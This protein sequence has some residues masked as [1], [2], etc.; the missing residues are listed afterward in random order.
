M[1]LK[2]WMKRPKTDEFAGN[3]DQLREQL[4]Q[5]GEQSAEIG[6]Q[7]NKL[8][9]I[10]Y[11]T[12]QEILAKIDRITAGMDAVQ[13]WQTDQEVNVARLNEMERQID[14]LTGIL[15]RWL[16]DIDY[17][18]AGLQGEDQGRWRQ[19]L[20]QWGGQLLTALAEVGVREMDLLGRTF[21]PQWA[22]S[23]GTVA[24]DPSGVD[25]EITRL[26]VP[27]EVVS[28]IKRGFVYSD[29][30]LLRKAQVISIQED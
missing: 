11:K 24:R 27:Y 19:L 17:V 29:G 1:N 28:V 21:N 25:G 18:C 9:R 12:G 7:M 8:V 14:F 16:D 15:V 22:E 30:R 10:Q 2:F 20:E 23:I 4:S 13:R 3:T 6:V 26:L 5:L